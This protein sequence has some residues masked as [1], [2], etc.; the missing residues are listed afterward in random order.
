M[1]IPRWNYKTEALLWKD[2]FSAK[3]LKKMSKCK[4]CCSKLENSWSKLETETTAIFLTS[5]NMTQHLSTKIYCPFFTFQEQQLVMTQN[6][7][8]KSV[9][10]WRNPVVFFQ[11]QVTGEAK[12]LSLSLGIC[13]AGWSENS[14]AVT[15]VK[16]CVSDSTFRF[17][18][19]LAYTYNFS[20]TYL[21]PWGVS[22][23]LMFWH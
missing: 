18:F 14:T 23:V 2:V 5:E 6:L 3:F 10:I 1:Y 16:F 4:K 8:F 22:Y 17:R 9:C 20:H 11:I 21:P 19:L 7:I 15:S 12:T 13:K